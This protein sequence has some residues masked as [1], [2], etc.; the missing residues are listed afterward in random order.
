MLCLP[1]NHLNIHLDSYKQE[2]TAD[3]EQCIGAVDTDALR[4]KLQG[5]SRQQLQR[6]AKKAGL[7]ANQKSSVI[8]KEIVA[9]RSASG[10]CRYPHQIVLCTSLNIDLTRLLLC[11]LMVAA[12]PA[13]TP[14]ALKTKAQ[15][16]R[17]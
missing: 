15:V 10:I 16:S 4:E 3:M 11:L 5:L 7:P 14:L 6:E 12:T 9:I 2:R 13:S 1:F 8:V 17:V